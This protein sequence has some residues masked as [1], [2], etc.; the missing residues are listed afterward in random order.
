LFDRLP[1]RLRDCVAAFLLRGFDH[2]LRDRIAAFPFLRFPHWLGHG[3]AAF[4]F[5]R[6]P[7]RLRDCVAAF[8]LR[9]LDHGC[10][11]RVAAFPFLGLPYWLGYGVTAF[12]FDSFPNRL[13]DDSFAL[14]VLRFP[15]RAVAGLLDIFPH[16]L[17]N[18]SHTGNFLS[19][20]DGFSN[21]SL[22]GSAFR[23]ARDM[24]TLRSTASNWATSMMGHA[25]MCGGGRLFCR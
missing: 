22:F 4:L 3:V 20:P 1:Y 7:H 8:L 6:L 5:D 13:G 17:A 21:R 16:G 19:F 15:F 23:R 2:G 12:L 18:G 10:R 11:D 24:G 14:A 25:T 9:G